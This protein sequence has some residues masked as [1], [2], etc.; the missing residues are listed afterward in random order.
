MEAAAKSVGIPGFARLD[1]DIA[2]CRS[3]FELAGE[4]PLRGQPSIPRST[5]MAAT[6]VPVVSRC[7]SCGKARGM[8]RNA[9]DFA[10]Y[11]SVLPRAVKTVS[12]TRTTSSIELEVAPVNV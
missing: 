11:R 6:V 3:V 8:M 9:W 5:D 10:D 1:G 12:I 4:Q 2:G 7:R